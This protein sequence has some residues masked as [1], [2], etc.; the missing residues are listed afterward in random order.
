LNEFP[1]LSWELMKKTASSAG[2]NKMKLELAP[3]PVPVA[4]SCEILT[5]ILKK[6]YGD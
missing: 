4:Q 6:S 1:G 2:E 3:R 5:G